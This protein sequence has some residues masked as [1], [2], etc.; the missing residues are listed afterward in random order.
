MRKNSKV[1]IIK[2]AWLILIIVIFNIWYVHAKYV[3][4]LYIWVLRHIEVH[5]RLQLNIL[6]QS[7]EQAVIK[8][9]YS[10]CYLFNRII[11]PKSFMG[12]L[13]L[14]ANIQKHYLILFNLK[15]RN[16]QHEIANPFA[17]FAVWCTL[18]GR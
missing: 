17:H 4:S 10:I 6:H 5:Q 16:N 9:C 11:V 14:L 3:Q 7:N 1:L 15:V 13:I 2:N 12:T 18:L 8:H